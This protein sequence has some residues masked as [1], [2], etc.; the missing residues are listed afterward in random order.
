MLSH[1]SHF[2]LCQHRHGPCVFTDTMD[3]CWV[4]REL[5]SCSTGPAESDSF[6]KESTILKHTD[7]KGKEAEREENKKRRSK[8]KKLQSEKES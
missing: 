7:E 6:Q 1:L 8:E 2:Q 3:R 4:R 5:E